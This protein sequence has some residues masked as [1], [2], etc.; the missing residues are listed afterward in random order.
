[1]ATSVAEREQE[2]L[3][4]KTHREY[5]AMAQHSNVYF[6]AKMAQEVYNGAARLLLVL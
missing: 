1:M 3:D 4:K 6:Y 2:K 5:Q